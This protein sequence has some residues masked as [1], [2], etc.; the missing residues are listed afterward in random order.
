MHPF[1]VPSFMDGTNGAQPEMTY[2]YHFWSSG[3]R[4]STLDIREEIPCAFLDSRLKDVLLPTI[5]K[6]SVK[7]IANIVSK[8]ENCSGAKS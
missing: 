3:V 1:A 2:L 6:V 5:H 8:R 4:I 7:S